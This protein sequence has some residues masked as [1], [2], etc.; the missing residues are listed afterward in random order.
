MATYFVY[1]SSFY[2]G[3]TNLQWFQYGVDV[4]V[5]YNDI[6]VLLST[7]VGT[8]SAKVAKTVFVP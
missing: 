1:A 6:N 7:A 8:S 3:F 4:A 5:C 2:M